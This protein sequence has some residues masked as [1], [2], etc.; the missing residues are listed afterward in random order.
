MDTQDNWSSNILN[1]SILPM[2]FYNG[3]T[4]QT[5]KK[6]LFKTFYQCLFRMDLLDK[7]SNNILNQSILST[8]FYNGHTGQ[9]D[10]QHIYSKHSTHVFLE[11]THRTNRQTSYEIKAFYPY[12]FRVDTQSTRSINILNQS[13]LSM[14]FYN[15][16][17]G[18]TDKQH[19]YSK[20]S[21]HVFLEWTQRTNSKTT[22]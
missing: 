2:S 17:T 14:P 19:I 13:I 5:A 15:G 22:Y 10:I 1:H 12:L 20:Y 21:T 11:W 4:L 3:N 6:Y 7:R 18:Q 8:P 16:H 9:T